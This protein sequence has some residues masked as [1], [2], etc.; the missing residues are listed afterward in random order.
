MRA[1]I[2]RH[3]ETKKNIG[4]KFD[5]ITDNDDL[6]VEGRKQLTLL[7]KYLCKQHKAIPAIYSSPRKRSELTAKGIANHFGVGYCIVEKLPPINPGDLSGL[8]EVQARER[9]PLLMETR[10]RFRDGLVDGYKIS[11]PGGDSV[12]N[13]EN[14]ISEG[15]HSLLLKNENFILITHRSVILALFN[16]FSKKFFGHR[17]D[18]YF[19]FDTPK[20]LILELFINEL[21]SSGDLK[22]IGSYEM[23]KNEC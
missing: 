2:V 9:Y 19:Y 17:K 12:K 8:T 11:F 15:I 18:K 1:L 22:V 10:L 16:I 13:Y 20:G 21:D 7:C 4:N 3:C 5:Q 6:T 23:W 14:T